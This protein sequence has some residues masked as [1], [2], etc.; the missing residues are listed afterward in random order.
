VRLRWRGFG[1][2]SATAGLLTLA[3]SAH[4]VGT[5]AGLSI[6][7]QASASYSIQGAPQ[8][9]VVSNVDRL[10]V[11]EILDSL[12]TSDDAAP[13]SVASPSTANVLTF[14]IANT[15]NGT[16]PMRLVA[17]PQLS[18]DAF[19]PSQVAIYLETNGT[20]GLQTGAGGDAQYTA[21]ANDPALAANAVTVAYVVGDVPSAQPSGALS[22]VGLRAVAKTIFTQ[23]G[24]DD[25]SNAAFPAPGTTY[26]NAGDSGP[27]GPVAAVVGK[28]ADH[29]ALALRA[30]GTFRVSS[31]TVTIVK[32]VRAI[33]DPSGGAKVVPGAT[34]DYQISVNI[35]GS[36]TA[37]GV[38]VTD[39]IP[40]ELEYVS[41]SLAVSALPSG[42]NADDDFLPTGVDHT[43]F[44]AATQTVIVSLGDAV[45]GGAPT[46]IEFKA[47]VR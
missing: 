1:S 31:A 7:T 3:S 41:G 2:L 27:Q 9:D 12:V 23:S 6:D 38:T 26:P 47:K 33:N 44:D 17:E 15:G 11:D 30:E 37:T 35:G 24:T 36:G 18:G 40:T 46:T 43:G 10:A 19:D 34:I 13:V 8:P 29:T 20:P 28:S 22:N 5:T 14:S 32:T 42:E 21:G 4:A 25:P 45:G 39:P 16:E